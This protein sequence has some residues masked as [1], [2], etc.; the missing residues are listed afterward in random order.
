MKPLYLRPNTRLERATRW[1][2]VLKAIEVTIEII[3]SVTAYA[4][5]A[6]KIRI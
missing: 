5:I 1:Y 2:L 4:M 3:S 6:R